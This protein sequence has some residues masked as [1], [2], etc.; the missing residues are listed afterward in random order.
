M[1]KIKIKIIGFYLCFIIPLQ[2]LFIMPSMSVQWNFI[3]QSKPCS[4]II[5]LHK[6]LCFVNLHFYLVYKNGDKRSSWG[7]WSFC[8]IQSIN[9]LIFEINQE[10][11]SA[12][13]WLWT[14]FVDVLL[15]NIIYEKPVCFFCRMKAVPKYIISYIRTWILAKISYFYCPCSAASPVSNLESCHGNIVFVPQRF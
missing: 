6:K 8:T 9:I 1:T 10:S 14:H 7:K 15:E 12:E 3:L 4:S 2:W 13:Q 11:K 5:W